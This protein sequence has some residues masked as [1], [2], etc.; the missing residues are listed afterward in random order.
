M[1]KT[2]AQLDEL[3]MRVLLEAERCKDENTRDAWYQVFAELMFN[4]TVH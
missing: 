1:R 4:P 2:L 3:M